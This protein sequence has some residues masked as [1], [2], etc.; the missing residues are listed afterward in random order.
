MRAVEAEECYAYS[1]QTHGAGKRPEELGELV[2]G[3]FWVSEEYINRREKKIEDKAVYQPLI[4]VKQ[5]YTIPQLLAN[6]LYVR[7]V[8]DNHG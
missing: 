2:V 8:A 7:I 6:F 4:V 5:P 1:V 3:C